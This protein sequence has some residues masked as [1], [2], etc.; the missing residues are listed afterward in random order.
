MPASSFRQGVLAAV[1][2]YEPSTLAVPTEF[3]GEAREWWDHFGAWAIP[4]GVVEVSDQPDP[5]R[6]D[7]RP[8]EIG[9]VCSRGN[10]SRHVSRLAQAALKYQISSFQLSTC[11]KGMSEV[12][13]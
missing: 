8:Q 10:R 7:Y 5:F 13:S 6:S 1:H 12:R 2:S 3:T 9:W 11:V 4:V